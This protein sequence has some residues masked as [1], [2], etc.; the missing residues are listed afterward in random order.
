MKTKIQDDLVC[1]LEESASFFLEETFSKEMED[2]R[3]QS[4][5]IPEEWEL[6]KPTNNQRNADIISKTKNALRDKGVC[7]KCASW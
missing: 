2:L 1:L 3:L 4:D 6:L 7:G 5:L